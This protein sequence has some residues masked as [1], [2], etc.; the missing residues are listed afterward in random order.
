MTDTARLAITLIA[1]GD[2]GNAD[3]INAAFQDIDTAA[4]KDSDLTAHMA[5]TSTHGVGV[6]VGTTETQTLS[7]KSYTAPDITGDTE[8]IDTG[9]AVGITDFV[10]TTRFF[11]IQE[12]TANDGGARLWGFS[13]SVGQSPVQLAGSFGN[14]NPTDSVPAVVITGSKRSGTGLTALAAAETVFRITNNVT[15]LLDLLGDGTLT[16]TGDFKLAGRFA[17]AP[18]T[19]TL[20]ANDQTI[21]VPTSSGTVFVD[22]G[23]LNRTGIR[24]AAG[25]YDGQELTIVVTST[26]DITFHATEATGRVAGTGTWPVGVPTKRGM[27]FVWGS[28]AAR[29]FALSDINIA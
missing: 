3:A 15:T 4:A 20:T 19:Q 12:V 13:D 27:K 26:T 7:G 22:A 5:D 21:T 11:V 6:V 24:I 14:T 1:E 17:T 9:L 2:P 16:L 8:F 25:T 28:S 23:A 29:W 18:A 10:P